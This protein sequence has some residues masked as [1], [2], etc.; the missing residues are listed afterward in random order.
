MTN[1]LNIK[2]RQGHHLLHDTKK[3]NMFRQENYNTE[4]KH[5]QRQKLKT[6]DKD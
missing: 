3:I 5:S 2:K 1:K 4:E 6:I